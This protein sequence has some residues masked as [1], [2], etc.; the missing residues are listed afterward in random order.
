MIGRFLEHSRVYYF[1]NDGNDELWIGSADLMERNLSR[2]VETLCPILD[3]QLRKLIYENIL[4]CHLKDNMRSYV[5]KATGQY[6]KVQK[7]KNAEPINSQETLI[8]YY[9]HLTVAE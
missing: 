8:D 2:R 7:S 4:M 9:S 1:Q 3:A 5:M 6:E